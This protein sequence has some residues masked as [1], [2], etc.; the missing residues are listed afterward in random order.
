MSVAEQGCISAGL[1]PAANSEKPPQRLNLEQG[2]STLVPF[3]LALFRYKSV[4]A[5]VLWDIFPDLCPAFVPIH[6]D[7]ALLS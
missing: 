1:K 3:F 5:L 7:W 6:R 4:T 2:C